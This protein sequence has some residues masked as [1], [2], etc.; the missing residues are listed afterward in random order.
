MIGWGAHLFGSQVS[1][2][3]YQV[4]V[5]RYGFGFRVMHF[6]TAYRQPPSPDMG[7]VERPAQPRLT[8]PVSPT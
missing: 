6:P 3:G 7:R 1:A 8:E 4:Q 5:F 2:I